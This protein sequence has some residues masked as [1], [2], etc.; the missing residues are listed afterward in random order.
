[1]SEEQGCSDLSGWQWHRANGG[2]L[3]IIFEA[4]LTACRPPRLKG[5]KKVTRRMPVL[6]R[7]K[8]E[9]AIPIIVTRT[10][11]TGPFDL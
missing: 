10:R 3:D 11:S 4:F 5:Q 9:Q 1:L 6:A 2:Q 7:E 8:Q